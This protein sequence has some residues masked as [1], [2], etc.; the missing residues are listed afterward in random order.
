M[1]N[2][3]LVCLAIA[4]SCGALK[5]RPDLWLQ[6]YGRV[7]LSSADIRHQLKADYRQ[8][9]VEMRQR[10]EAANDKEFG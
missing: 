8:T 10:L 3:N 2:L 6:R 9:K 7:N 5:H 4:D 1:N